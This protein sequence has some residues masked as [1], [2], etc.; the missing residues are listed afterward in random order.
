ME[1][2]D[3]D[4]GANAGRDAKPEEMMLDLCDGSFLGHMLSGSALLSTLASGDMGGDVEKSQVRGGSQGLG[5]LYPGTDL[6]PYLLSIHPPFPFLG[7]SG[8]QPT[9]NALSS[10]FRDRFG[11][12]EMV[13]EMTRQETDKMRKTLNSD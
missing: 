12:L 8:L 3:G 4:P 5:T 9:G 1:I 13:M 7:Y 11:L 2:S 10:S 6:P